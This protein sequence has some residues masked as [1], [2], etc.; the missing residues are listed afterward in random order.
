MTRGYRHIRYAVDEGVATIT[1]DRPEK[2]NAYVPE[3]GDEVVAAFR[4]ACGDDAVRVVILTGAGRGFC[5][6]VD[7]EA[8][9]ASSAAA[10]GR[11]GP[12]LGEEDFVRKLP[13]EL[14][15]FPKPTIAAINGH[16][17]GVGVTMTLPCDVRL[18]AADA[19]IGLTFAKLGILPGLGSTHLLPRLVGM[20]HAQ[21]LVLTAR[22]ILG[23]EA[24]AIGLVNRA[25]PREAVLPAAVEMARAM[26][27]HDPAVL[28][29]ARQALHQGAD[30]D[31]ADALANERRH[32]AS[33]RA[34]RGPRASGP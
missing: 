14:H 4:T 9:Q 6:G 7:L 10:P 13:L 25:L 11:T 28:A 34:R 20:A 15:G 3:M 18:A 29:A 8:L 2:L 16:A 22:V 21:E 12:R 19:K 24:A 27:Q 33:L 32:S 5:A 23:D 1:L 30:L 17:I 31:L 26:A